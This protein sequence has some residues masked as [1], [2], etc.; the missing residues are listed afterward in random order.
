MDDLYQLV[1]MADGE[2]MAT[3]ELKHSYSQAEVNEIIAVIQRIRKIQQTVLLA[4]E[5]YIASAAQD[6]KYR[7]E[8]PFKLQGSY[9]NMNKM[10]EKVVPV[11]TE[12]E[13]ESLIEDH[14]RGEAQTLTVGA[15]E[16]L[17]K[18]A[19]LRETQ[20]DEQLARWQQIKADYVRHQNLGD[21]DNPI[22][23]I[24]NQI[25]LLQQGL[26]QIGNVLAQPKSEGL[27]QLNETLSALK[28]QVNVEQA[29]D[30]VL[31]QTLT[32]FSENLESFLVPLVEAVQSKNVQAG[33]PSEHA[34]E[35]IPNMQTSVK[36]SENDIQKIS[37]E[38]SNSIQSSV[39]DCL[40]QCLED[41]P[42]LAKTD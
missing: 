40:S 3:T 28:L 17:L 5:Q 9:R 31:R 24:A 13:V 34:G 19:E 7:I 41:Y 42:S 29:D 6:D 38:L 33:N 32:Q 37:R 35:V 2:P 30:D 26:T 15:E 12:T 11:M 14:Y 22:A 25:S 39:T 8:P 16:N 23:S 20:N 21:N 36:V 27:Q 4:N 18:L 1:K 10:A